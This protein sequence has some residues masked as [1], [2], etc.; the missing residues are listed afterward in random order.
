M[1]NFNS[2]QE[3]SPILLRLVWTNTPDMDKLGKSLQNLSNQHVFLNY[4]VLD[5][6]FYQVI[7]LIPLMMRNSWGVMPIASW[8][9]RL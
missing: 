6:T 9:L 3:K 8:N 4:L 1:A 5:G 7:L 2:L